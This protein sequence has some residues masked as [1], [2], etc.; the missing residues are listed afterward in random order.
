[1]YRKGRSGSFGM[2]QTPATIQL[3]KIMSLEKAAKRGLFYF[4]LNVRKLP[5]F[6][7]SA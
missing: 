3:N 1:M 5:S 6:S 7:L 4:P 2:L